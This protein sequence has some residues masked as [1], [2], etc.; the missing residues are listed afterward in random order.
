MLSK[1]PHPLAFNFMQ[2]SRGTQGWGQKGA[3]WFA[4]MLHIL[5]LIPRNIDI[6]VLE[7]S[8]DI[9]DLYIG[10]SIEVIP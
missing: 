6:S 7:H 5:W 8:E 1:S 2:D 3:E 10:I 9:F 4:L